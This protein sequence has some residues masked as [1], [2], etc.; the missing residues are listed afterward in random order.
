MKVDNNKIEIA[1]KMI[2]DAQGE[3]IDISGLDFLLGEELKKEIDHRR[4]YI[5]QKKILNDKQN[6]TEFRELTKQIKKT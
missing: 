6:D 2:Q 3:G 4:K 5:I 1:Q